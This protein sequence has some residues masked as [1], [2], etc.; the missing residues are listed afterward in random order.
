[1]LF[2]QKCIR[3]YAKI[4]F[5]WSVGVPI[6]SY[7]VRMYSCSLNIAFHMWSK[8]CAPLPQGTWNIGSTSVLINSSKNGVAQRFCIP[9]PKDTFPLAPFFQTNQQNYRY[10]IFFCTLSL[11][12]PYLSHFWFFSCY[13][14]FCDVTSLIMLVD[15]ASRAIH[16]LSLF[17]VT[18]PGLDLCLFKKVSQSGVFSFV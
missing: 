13:I 1:M 9:V 7:T 3:S 17:N 8:W 11:L 4:H 14:S 10:T 15:N 2:H 5:S 6:I 16:S 12:R 18:A